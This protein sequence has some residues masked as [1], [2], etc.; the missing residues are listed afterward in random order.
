MSS[1]AGSVLFTPRKIGNLTVMNRFMRSATWDANADAEGNPTD[2]ALELLVYLAQG[3]IGLIA[4]PAMTCDPASVGRGTF[5]MVNEGNR[6]SWTQFVES[7]QTR[8]NRVMFQINH[9]GAAAAVP[10]SPSGTGN[11]KALTNAEVEQIVDNFVK[12]CVLSAQAGVDAVQLHCA[13]GFLLGEFLSPAAN[14]RTDKWGGSLENRCRIVKEI[15]QEVR[16]KT[17]V[18]LS[19][20][21][22]GDDHVPGGITPATAPDVVRELVKDCDLF[23]ISCSNV[24]GKMYA[25]ASDFNQ[26]ALLKGVKDAKQKEE[27]LKKAHAAMDGIT[28]TEEFNRRAAEEIKRKVPEACVALVGGNRT[29]ANMEKLVK[30]GVCDIVSMSRPFL[31]DPF[32]VTK[33]W[34]GETD[35]ADCINC[36]ACLMNLTEGVFCHVN[37][38]RIW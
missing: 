22:N 37:K 32:L 28:F 18:M 8:G 12:A 29:F 13:H 14:R 27:I 2:E 9:K 31:K 20:K 16:K 10:V 26:A 30:D 24:N 4:G 1:R 5:A 7:I 3:E 19:I 11:S 15:L 17:N 36:S 35:K 6:D 38:E 33:F 25:L 21:M 34:R 23:E